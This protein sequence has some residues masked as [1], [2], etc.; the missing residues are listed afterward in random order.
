MKAKINVIVN[1]ADLRLIV[2]HCQNVQL[3]RR[4]IPQKLLNRIRTWKV[5][6]VSVCFIFLVSVSPVLKKILY[7]SVQ[8]AKQRTNVWCETVFCY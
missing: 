2:Q 5:L 6:R 1:S 3:V 4:A 8:N 7:P